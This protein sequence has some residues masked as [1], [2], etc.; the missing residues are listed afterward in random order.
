MDI[1]YQKIDG[2]GLLCTAEVEYIYIY[3]YLCNIY[4]CVPFRSF[5]YL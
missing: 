1:A 2:L 5:V 4:V 3:K